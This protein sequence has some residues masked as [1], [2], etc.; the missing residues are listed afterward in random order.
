MA[1]TRVEQGFDRAKFI[2]N[3]IKGNKGELGDRVGSTQTIVIVGEIQAKLPGSYSKN[4]TSKT[5]IIPKR[6]RQ[7]I[8][9][10]T[11]IINDGGKIGKRTNRVLEMSEEQG[12]NSRGIRKLDLESVERS[13]TMDLQILQPAYRCEQQFLMI[14]LL[15]EDF[16]CLFVV[17]IRWVRLGWV[18]IFVRIAYSNQLEFCLHDNLP[19]RYLMIILLCEDLSLVM[20]YDSSQLK[21]CAWMY[22]QRNS[23]A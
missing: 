9:V 3:K 6:M 15:R 22:V 4:K 19:E 17:K 16:V 1:S 2:N 7:T 12:E 20:V 23:N 21:V 14:I 8:V 11:T 13:L 10:E 5:T 18:L